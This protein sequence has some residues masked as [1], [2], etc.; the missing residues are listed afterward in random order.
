MST[1]APDL[2]T[3]L[4]DLH[5]A[6]EH[7]PP[8]HAELTRWCRRFPEHAPAIADHVA[9]WVLLEAGAFGVAAE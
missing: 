7:K 4:F 6:H 9:T 8:T 1:S 3:I 2:E 5:C